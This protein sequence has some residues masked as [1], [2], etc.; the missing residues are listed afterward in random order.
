MNYSNSRCSDKAI[1]IFHIA[2]S[3]TG[4]PPLLS[5]RL[6][7]LFFAGQIGVIAHIGQPVFQTPLSAQ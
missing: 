6:A 3:S 7:F 4:I 5:V 2:V 1:V